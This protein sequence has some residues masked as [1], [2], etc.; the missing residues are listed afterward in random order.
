MIY[1]HRKVMFIFTKFMLLFFKLKPKVK[2]KGTYL[3]DDN[4]F[5]ILKQKSP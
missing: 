5:T 3:N 2:L 1:V 4:M